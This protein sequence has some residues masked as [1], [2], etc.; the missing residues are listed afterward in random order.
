MRTNL[1]VETTEE[2]NQES[3]HPMLKPIWGTNNK[4]ISQ[5]QKVFCIEG[6]LGAKPTQRINPSNL[7]KFSEDP[8]ELLFI[9]QESTKGI[10]RVFEQGGQSIK[11]PTN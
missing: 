6:H 9:R 2:W 3:M 1:K 4:A 8:I 11:I 10:R 7:N 5:L